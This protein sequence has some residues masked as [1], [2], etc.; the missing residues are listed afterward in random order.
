M[1]AEFPE[2]AKLEQAKEM[3]F[4]HLTAG[5]LFFGL[6]AATICLLLA[7]SAYYGWREL[8]SDLE[9]T[10]VQGIATGIAEG[11]EGK[12]LYVHIDK[13]DSA[14]DESQDCQNSL[15]GMAC[16]SPDYY[17]DFV[18]SESGEYELM[19]IFSDIARPLDRTFALAGYSDEC[20]GLS[21]YPVE[22]F[23]HKIDI[24]TTEVFV[25]QVY[26]DGSI[27]ATFGEN[28][29]RML[30]GEEW[31]GQLIRRDQQC[32]TVVRTQRIANYGWISEQKITWGP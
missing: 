32:D 21:L 8:P 4:S 27:I 28:A 10:P 17:V 18:E 14:Q 5:F 15:A 26:P 2:L 9:L 19:H 20:G 6:L 30:P 13:F 12:Y 7:L 11:P 29:Y 24:P 3:R 1:P 22:A 31:I 16:A 23:P 25:Q